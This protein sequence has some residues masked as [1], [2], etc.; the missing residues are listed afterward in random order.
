MSKTQKQKYLDR[1]YELRMAKKDKGNISHKWF[2]FGTHDASKCL[3]C[4]RKVLNDEE[5][6]EA[7]E[8]SCEFD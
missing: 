8:S 4:G 3:N 2:P 7:N 6:E 1:V 5:L